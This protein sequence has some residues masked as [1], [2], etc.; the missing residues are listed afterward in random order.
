MQ[1]VE[2]ADGFD[3]P[4]G[5]PDAHGYYKARGFW[6]GTHPG[7]DWNGVNGGNTDLGDPV[8]SIGNGL[9]IQSRNVG[10]GWG[11]VIIV[12]HAYRNSSDRVTIIDS[13]YAHLQERL[14]EKGEKIARGQLLGTIGTASGK[15]LAHLHFEIR[16]N[17]NIGMRRSMFSR[18]YSNYHN[19]TK[20]ITTNRH[21]EKSGKDYLIP[22]G[23]SNSVSIVDQAIVL[24][25]REPTEILSK[26]ATQ[27]RQAKTV[28]KRS[29]TK[30]SATRTR[31]VST[32]TISPS[33]DK[34]NDWDKIET[35]WK[36]FKSKVFKETPAQPTK[37][38]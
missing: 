6:T 16:K 14:I 11:N 25:K 36:H 21:I 26:K 29:N 9:V 18:D 1:K 8:Y 38:D 17:L 35:F 15:Y 23:F 13:L 10:A 7:E 4:V 2:L 20:F 22:T 28:T 34:H 27:E 37:K 24:E 30:K 5:A 19:P 33:P 12:R 3:Y 32:K 31:G